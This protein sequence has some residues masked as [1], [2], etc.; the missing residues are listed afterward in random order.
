MTRLL[1]ATVAQKNDAGGM[2]VCG[3]G[4]I[5]MGL[6]RRGLRRVLSL[7]GN[8]SALMRTTTRLR[9]SAEFVNGRLASR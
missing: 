3:L 2:F 5:V 9:R 4:L 7:F 8:A 1:L 6:S